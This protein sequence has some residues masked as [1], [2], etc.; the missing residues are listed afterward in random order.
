MLSSVTTKS[1]F[2]FVREW[3]SSAFNIL[4]TN[5]CMFL[6]SGFYYCN[7]FIT[8]SSYTSVT[9]TCLQQKRQQL[10]RKIIT[11]KKGVIANSHIFSIQE[12]FTLKTVKDSVTEH[13]TN[14]FA[15]KPTRKY[16]GNTARKYCVLYC[17]DKYCC[18]VS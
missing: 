10:T 18:S 13:S 16:A 8:K 9:T 15:K 4:M 3:T 14:R 1:W 2:F 5:R 12:N 6:S 7:P 11:L 17:G